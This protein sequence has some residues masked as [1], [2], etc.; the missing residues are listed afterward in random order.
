MPEV[1]VDTQLTLAI[2]DG[3][4]MN[5]A[6]DCDKSEDE[7]VAPLCYDVP[8]LLPRIP[9]DEERDGMLMNESDNEDDFGDGDQVSVGDDDINLSIHDHEGRD[10]GVITPIMWKTACTFITSPSSLINHFPSV[11][12]ILVPICLQ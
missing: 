11:V 5:H 10:F 9:D 1:D 2:K 12:F 6:D 8:K 4:V 3:S 7:R